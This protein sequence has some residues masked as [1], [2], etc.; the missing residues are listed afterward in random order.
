MPLTSASAAR[1]PWTLGVN[2]VDPLVTVLAMSTGHPTLTE[3][4]SIESAKISYAVVTPPSGVVIAPTNSV[5]DARSITG[6]PVTPNGSMFPHGRA[7][8]GTGVP[9][10]VC[11]TC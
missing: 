3:P 1:C 6:V 8:S 9:T 11:Q 2:V 10:E 4:S 5:R 7:P